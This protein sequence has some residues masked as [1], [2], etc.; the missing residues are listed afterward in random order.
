MLTLQRCRQHLRDR[1]VELP[2]EEL[3]HLMSVLHYLAIR[4]CEQAELERAGGGVRGDEKEQALQ[5]SQ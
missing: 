3:E 1:G 5:I 2:D 4:V